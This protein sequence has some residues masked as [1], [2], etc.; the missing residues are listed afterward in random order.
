M[1]SH[2]LTS[3]TRQ[4]IASGPRYSPIGDNKTPS[5]PKLFVCDRCGEL[6]DICDRA[7]PSQFCLECKLYMDVI[8]DR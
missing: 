2:Y 6:K 3:K 8:T 4:T 5:L 1:V 7:S